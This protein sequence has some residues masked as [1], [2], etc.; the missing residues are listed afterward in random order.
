MDC[1]ARGQL[2][3]A[4]QC[5]ARAIAGGLD[6][7]AAHFTLGLLCLERGRAPEARKALVVSIQDPTYREASQ[8][9]LGR[10]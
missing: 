10:L 2:D 4:I 6:L 5:Y 9:A 3:D 7:A 1:Q 8:I